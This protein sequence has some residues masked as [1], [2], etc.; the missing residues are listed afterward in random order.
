VGIVVV[1]IVAILSRI[2][3][4][5]LIG[6]ASSRLAKAQRR[7]GMALRFGRRRELDHDVSILILP[8]E[9]PRGACP[10]SNLST[11]IMRPPQHGHG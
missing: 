11:R 5:S 2:G 7:E 1:F 4:R 9:E 8:G 6:R 3:A 10:R